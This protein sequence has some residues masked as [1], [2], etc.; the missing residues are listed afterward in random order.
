MSQV[1]EFDTQTSTLMYAA[2]KLSVKCSGTIIGNQVWTPSDTPP[3]RQVVVLLHGLFAT[4]RSM[5][6]AAEHLEN[7]GFD[8]IN[9]GYPTL[10]RTIE[11]HARRLLPTLQELERDTG[12]QSISFV[13]HSFGGILARYVIDIG[14]FHKLHRMVML[15]PPNAG[16]HLTKLSLGPF[17]RFLPAIAELS[18]TPQSL[19]NRLRPPE[20]IEIGVIAA[21]A[22]F[23]VRVANTRLASQREHCVVKAT[24]F[25]LPHLDEVLVKAAHF[26]T[27]GSFQTIP[28]ARPVAA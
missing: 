1:D 19:P 20:G 3:G 22:D 17:R 23:I 4:T 27:A 21:S 5:C 15:A 2:R 13:T 6:K 28:L 12:V 9:W 26:L 11:S 16:S 8:V 7:L 10:W 25:Q 24:H 14:D 18:E